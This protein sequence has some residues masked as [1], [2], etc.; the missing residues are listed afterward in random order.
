MARRD[1][2]YQQM[3]PQ[4]R[5]PVEEEAPQLPPHP[6]MMRDEMAYQN[7]G[8][9]RFKVL[10]SPELQEYYSWMAAQVG[11]QFHPDQR[12]VPLIATDEAEILYDTKSNPG[13]PICLNA[14][15]P[16]T[17]L[18]AYF[19]DP[20]FIR[21][22]SCSLNGYVFTEQAACGIESLPPGAFESQSLT[23]WPS[24]GLNIMDYI[25]IDVKRDG[26]SQVFTENPV[27]LSAF[28]GTGP[29]PYFWSPIPIIKR[30]GSLIFKLSILP[31]G[32][33]NGHPNGPPFVKQVGFFQLQLHCEVFQPF[34]T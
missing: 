33:E 24:P 28:C 26:S 9:Q 27:A 23:N 1:P 25:F 32:Q 22:V 14:D 13:E 18:R 20:A 31:P 7:A 21:K 8:E 5:L 17:E 30:A 4:R 12:L 6:R 11:L 29:H 15:R 2:R 10:T 34:G 3:M 16:T 19:D